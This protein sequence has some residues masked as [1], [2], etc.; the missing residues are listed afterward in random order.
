MIFLM[1][2]L[3]KY[4]PNSNQRHSFKNSY[5]TASPSLSQTS[6]RRTSKTGHNN[7]K[8]KLLKDDN[9]GLNSK[10]DLQQFI[11][12]PSSPYWSN[13]NAKRSS[14]QFQMTPSNNHNNEMDGIESGNDPGETDY[15]A[16]KDYF[17]ARNGLIENDV[18]YFDDDNGLDYD[19]NG[20]FNSINDDNI[21]D[22]YLYIN[23]LLGKK[24]NQKSI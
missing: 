13:E 1:K 2:T 3:Y 9:K 7:S 8:N 21:N 18:K 19:V 10:D 17:N 11:Q 5:K 22:F 24:P 15:R 23:Q 4:I 6:S 16:M 12:Y 20:F 14:Q